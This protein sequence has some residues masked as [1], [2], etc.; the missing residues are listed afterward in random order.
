MRLCQP[1]SE[2]MSL[3]A[4]LRR[5]E[6]LLNQGQPSTTAVLVEMSTGMDER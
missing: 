1:S 5:G 2:S 6:E 3:V 4:E